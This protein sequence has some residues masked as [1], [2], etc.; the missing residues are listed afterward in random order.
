MIV[1]SL[2]GS[3]INPGTIDKEFLAGLSQLIKEK[4]DENY[5]FVIVCGGGAVARQYIKA[6]PEGL[7]EGEKDIM[8]IEPTWLNSRLL[9]NY[10]HGYCSQVLPRHFENLI[11]QLERNK[12]AVCGGY[13]PALKTDEDAAIIA[14]YFNAKS[15][16]NITNVDAV[17]DRDPQKYPNAKKFSKLK[18]TEFF[19]LF[20]REDIGAGAN[21]PFTLIAT[22][23]AERVSIPIVIV[24]KDLKKIKKAIEN[25]FEP[26]IGTIIHT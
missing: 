23:I 11:E 7:S 18:Y 3:V 12:V 9:A 25:P 6:L 4:M 22:K 15:I 16:I 14:D 20:R 10:L 1:L 24:S 19:D 17:Y 26:E 13:L 5:Q 21:A 2:G 8:G